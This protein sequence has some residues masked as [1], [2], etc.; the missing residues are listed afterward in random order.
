MYK[1]KKLKFH[2]KRKILRNIIKRINAKAQKFT[3]S[4]GGEQ[5]R[6]LAKVEIAFLCIYRYFLL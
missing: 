6:A 5:N 4:N 1:N 3:I 2:V